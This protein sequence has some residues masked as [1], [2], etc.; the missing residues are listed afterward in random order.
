MGLRDVEKAGSVIFT[1]GLAILKKADSRRS[2]RR[3][4]G[5]TDQM[6]AWQTEEL[7]ARSWRSPAE[8]I[9]VYVAPKLVAEIAFNEIQMSPRKY[10]CSGLA[11]RFARVKRYRTDK[12]ARR[13]RIRLKWCG[14][15]A[16][17]PGDLI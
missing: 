1:W 11:L 10:T 9:V 17:D 13:S 4:K 15:L 14:K 5:L 8:G 2:G 7:P 3:S 6:L 16:G 12:T